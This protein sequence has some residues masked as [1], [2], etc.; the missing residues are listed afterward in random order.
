RA[1][2]AQTALFDMGHTLFRRRCHAE[3]Q[4]RRADDGQASRKAGNSVRAHLTLG[5]AKRAETISFRPFFSSLAL[6]IG[7]TSP[8]AAIGVASM[9]PCRLEAGHGLT[10]RFFMVPASAANDFV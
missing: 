2:D 4:S 6:P 8:A 10:D 1:G 9:F 5:A 3:G 7:W